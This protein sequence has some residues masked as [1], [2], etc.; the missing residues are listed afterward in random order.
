MKIIWEI[1]PC[2]VERVQAF[3]RVS[4]KQS[5]RSATWFDESPQGQ[6]SHLP[7]R[8]FGRKWSDACLTTQQRSGPTSPIS[9]FM[10]RPFPLRWEVCADQARL[11][12]FARDVMTEFGGIRR[13]TTIGNEMAKNMANM[14]GEVW[15]TTMSKLGRSSHGVQSCYRTNRCRPHRRH[16]CRI[17]A[18]AVEKPNT[19]AWAV[20]L[21]NPHRQPHYEVAESF[22]ISRQANRSAVAGSALLCLRVRRLPTAC[23][24]EWHLPV[25]A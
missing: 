2:D 6:A 9:K 4:Q 18:E 23:R 21:R 16:F 13:S 20:S 12:E 3:F 17:W 15:E 5:V 1:E 14:H 25:F 8:R 22:R 7:R 19:D 10:S 24:S 11:A